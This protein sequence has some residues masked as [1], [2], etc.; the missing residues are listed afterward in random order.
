MGPTGEVVFGSPAPVCSENRLRWDLTPEQIQQMSDE[1]IANTKTEYDR[2]GALDL[3]SVT[4]ENTLKALADVEV[5][6][7][8]QRNM[9]DFP[10]HVSSSKEVRAASTEADKRLSEFDVEMSMREDVYLRIVALEKKVDAE[11]L[12]AESRR[13]M[14]RL[15]KLGKR[16]GLHLSTEK[17]EEIKTIKKKLSN[18]CID[19]NKNLNEDTTCLSFSRDELGGLPEDFLSSLEPD[20]DKLKVTSSGTGGRVGARS[21]QPSLQHA[22]PRKNAKSEGNSMM[23][24]TQNA[25][26][27]EPRAPSESSTHKGSPRTGGIEPE[28]G[29]AHAQAQNFRKPMRIKQPY[30][31][32]VY[33]RA[34]HTVPRPVLGRAPVKSTPV[35]GPQP[36]KTAPLRAIQRSLTFK[37]CPT[38]T[39]G[40]ST[41]ITEH[42]QS[43]CSSP[44][45]NASTPLP[46]RTTK[47]TRTTPIRKEQETE[48]P[49]PMNNQLSPVLPLTPQ[50][51]EINDTTSLSVSPQISPR[52]HLP[53]LQLKD[54]N[55]CTAVGLR[56]V[57]A[58]VHLPPQHPLY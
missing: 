15:I 53:S 42:H 49:T 28:T 45:L 58:L 23:R 4:F 11:T 25:D 14:E 6:Y 10:Q 27:A 31:Y 19:F 8:V 26:V 30:S 20:G 40:S 33:A 39:S 29:S 54:N 32:S 34:T 47:H 1:L 36:D 21:R 48:N 7:T 17:Q 16:N 2:V 13:Y 18:L 35:Y 38:T 12:T 43:S 9:L 46:Q 3:E 51:K 56:V 44:P 50:N 55:L 22:H 57:E 24:G 37:K 41:T 5:E 52:D